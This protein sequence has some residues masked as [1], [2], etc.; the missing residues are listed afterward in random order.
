MF[1]DRLVLLSITIHI[2]IFVKIY[3]SKHIFLVNQ[4]M[5]KLTLKILNLY[6]E[7]CRHIKSLSKE[8]S[9]LRWNTSAFTAFKVVVSES[10]K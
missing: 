10:M 1:L 4:T 9:K 3:Y 2:L 8:S 7:K 5:Y 6:K